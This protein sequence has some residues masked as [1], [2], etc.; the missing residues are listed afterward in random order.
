MDHL[1]TQYQYSTTEVMLIL[2]RI[3]FSLGNAFTLKLDV[4]APLYCGQKVKFGVENI[5]FREFFSKSGLHVTCI[6]NGWSRRQTQVDF[7]LDLWTHKRHIFPSRK[8]PLPQL[9]LQL[10]YKA[11]VFNL[12]GS[13]F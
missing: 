10:N 8:H 7:Q 13:S 3:H 4:Q 5:K 12:S 1:Y 2:T 9:Y 6:I 11:Q